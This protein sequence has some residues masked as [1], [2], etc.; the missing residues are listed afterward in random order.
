MDDKFITTIVGL[1]MTTITIIASLIFAYN[2][3][4][5][6]LCTPMECESICRLSNTNVYSYENGKCVCDLGCVRAEHG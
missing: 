2:I 5:I 3:E 4:Y 1:V 6:G